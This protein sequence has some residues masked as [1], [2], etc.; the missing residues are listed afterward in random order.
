QGHEHIN[1]INAAEINKGDIL[2]VNTGDKIPVDG[3]IVSG[4]VLIDESMITGES[5]PVEK[6]TGDEVIGGTIITSGNIRMNAEKVGSETVLA[7]IIEMVRNAQ[8]KRPAIQK[9][10]DKISAI[11]VPVVVGISAITFIIWYLIIGVPLATAIMTSIAVL[12][13]S[14]PCAM[15]LATPTAVMVGIGRAA[16][17]GILIKGGNTLQEL[18]NIKTVVFDKTGT[19]TTG[20]FKIKNI[21]TY[22]GA[23]ETEVKNLLYSIEQHSSHPIAKSIV[24]EL[25]QKATLLNLPDV[26]E[27]KGMGLKASDDEGNQYFLGGA[28]AVRHLVENAAFNIYLVKNDKLIAAV[29]VEDE[30]KPSAKE[31]INNLKNKGIHTVLLSGDKKEKCEALA[32]LLNIDTVHSEQLPS[33]KLEIIEELQKSG[34]VAMVGDGINDAPALAKATVG[35]S[36]G[37]ATQ[38]AIQSAQVILLNGNDLNNV[39]NA[40]Q[41]GKHSVITIKQNFFWAFIYNIVAIPIAAMGMLSPMVAALAMAFSDVVVVGNS[42]RLK[43]KKIF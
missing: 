7:K 20:N 29:D 32:S 28:L 23:G 12:V 1:E 8:Q 10:G 36:L 4:T 26:S 15:G 14:C 33:Q 21:H 5:I 37:N 38:V 43:S 3:K 40:F 34:P 27:I 2:Q 42:I 41:V 30:I 11:F 18:S 19:L 13:I 35:I 24:S 9:L 39:I 25:K 22:N 6:S 31:V 16:K 17:N